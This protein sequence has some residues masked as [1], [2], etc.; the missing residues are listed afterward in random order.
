MGNYLIHPAKPLEKPG[1]LTFLM[2]RR[3]SSPKRHLFPPCKPT[4]KKLAYDF[5]LSTRQT[6]RLVLPA[7]PFSLVNSFTTSNFETFWPDSSAASATKSRAHIIYWSRDFRWSN[8]ATSALLQTRLRLALI[9]QLAALCSTWSLWTQLY[10]SAE[11]SATVWYYWAFA[12]S[13]LRYLPY[14][15]PS[16]ARE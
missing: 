16:T 2:L 15:H 13:Y 10:I 5:V 11:R 1:P 4:C 7:V 14:Y 3:L 9:S 8:I 12:W 6:P